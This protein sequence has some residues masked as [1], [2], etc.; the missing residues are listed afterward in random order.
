MFSEAGSLNA[1]LSKLLKINELIKV[2]HE[3]MPDVEDFEIV[4]CL[5]STS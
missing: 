3:S 2:R 1:N 5:F 4:T